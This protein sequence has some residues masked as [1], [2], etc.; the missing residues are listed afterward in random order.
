MLP[1]RRILLPVDYSEPCRAVVPYVQDML[2]RFNAE[3]T[4][5][6][7]YGPVAA[8]VLAGSQDH[9][10]DPDFPE[11]VHA[12]ERERLHLFGQHMLAGRHVEVIAV[13]GEPGR[14]IEKVAQEQEVD[15]IMLA[16]HGYG[17]VRRFLLGSVTAKVLHDASTPVWTG[18]GSVLADHAPDLPYRS[19]LCALSD[20]GEA[21]VVLR[22][23]ASLAHAYNAQLS[24]LHT[25]QSPAAGLADF[26]DTRRKLVA[27]A[28]DRLRE[29]NSKL[30]LDVRITVIDGAVSDSVRGEVLRRKADLVITGRGHSQGAVSRMWSNLYSIVRESPVPVLSV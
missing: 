11:Q 16:T 13:L 26:R 23:A 17:P 5:V 15:L 7:A 12:A 2:R 24:V 28:H 20:D 4:L 14:V 30:N 22:A 6:H 1:F 27:A 8:A 25:V 3:L 29:L 18:I 21:E 9:L 10:I 19:M